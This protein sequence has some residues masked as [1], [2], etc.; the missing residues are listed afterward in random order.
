MEWPEQQ[1]RRFSDGPDLEAPPAAM[2]YYGYPRAYPQYGYY[3]YY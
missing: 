3:P 2:P 1:Q